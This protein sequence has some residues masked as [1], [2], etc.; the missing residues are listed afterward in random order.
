M[1]DGTL[2]R[3]VGVVHAKDIIPLAVAGRQN[4]PLKTLMR[5]PLFVSHDQTTANVLELFRSQRGHLAIVVDAYNRT[6]GLVSRNDLFRH[7][8]GGSETGA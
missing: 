5:R 8:T 4:P 7:L 2:D 6:L 3:I 1:V